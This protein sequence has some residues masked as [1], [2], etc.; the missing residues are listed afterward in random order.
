MGMFD[1]VKPVNISHGSFKQSHN[2]YMF[3]TKSLECDMSEYCVFNGVLYQEVDNSEKFKRHDYA[4]RF[5]YSGDLN[6]YTHIVEGGVE[7]WV[8][9]DLVFK[10]GELVDVVPYE[11][12]VTRDDRDLSSQRPGK[13][14]NR[15]EVTISVLYC[16]SGK[17]DAFIDSLN[18]EKIE[19][20]RDILGEPTATVFYPVKNSSTTMIGLKTIASV[21]QLREDVEHCLKGMG[22]V[23]APNGDKI[24]FYLDEYNLLR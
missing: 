16:E 10:E 9:Y 15:V 7:R 14:E 24:T 21:V 6:I 23:T 1:E 2:G 13:P 20:I 22:T 5:D 17:Q 8:E 12:R 4:M 19:A 18:D 3:Q 11:E